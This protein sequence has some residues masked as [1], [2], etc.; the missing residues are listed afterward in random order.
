MKIILSGLVA[1][2]LVALA[3]LLHPRPVQLWITGP[4]EDGYGPELEVPEWGARLRCSKH[5][6]RDTDSLSADICCRTSEPM[7]GLGLVPA[8]CDP[9]TPGIGEQGQDSSAESL[10]SR[11]DLPAPPG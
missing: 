4:A 10:P 3:A 11:A 7:P 2:A 8:A 6:S 1:F 5:G 9:A